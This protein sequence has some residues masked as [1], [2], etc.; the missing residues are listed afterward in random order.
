MLL[1]HLVEGERFCGQLKAICDPLSAILMLMW[2]RVSWAPSAVPEV[3]ALGI[4]NGFA[5]L[6]L[7][8]PE[9]EWCIR[10]FP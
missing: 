1:S 2:E 5:L 9:Q 7:G 3:L 10:Y 8:H 6:M 4:Q